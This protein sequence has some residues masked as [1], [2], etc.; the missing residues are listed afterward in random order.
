M[1]V[2]RAKQRSFVSSNK[3]QWDGSVDTFNVVVKDVKETMHKLC[4]GYVLTLQFM[5]AY[6]SCGLDMTNNPTFH[7]AFKVSRLTPL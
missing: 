6:K 5:P 4:M 3:L 2:G 1:C 7:A